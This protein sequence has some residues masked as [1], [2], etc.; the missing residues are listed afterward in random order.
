PGLICVTCP[1]TSNSAY[2]SIS[3]CATCLSSSAS[4]VCCSSARCSKLLGGNLYPPAIRGSVVFPLAPL[5][6][7]SVTSGATISTLR[8]G[9]GRDLCLCV[10]RRGHTFNPRHARRSW[11]LGRFNGRRGALIKTFRYARRTHLRRDHRLGGPPFLQ[12]LLHFPACPF[13]LPVPV[14]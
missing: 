5:S 8:E 6:A 12:V 1:W 13:I 14:A 2:F 11:A 9:G 3:T 7:R 10:S 4:I